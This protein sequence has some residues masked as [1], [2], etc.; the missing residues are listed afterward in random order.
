M[1]NKVLI[2]IPARYDSSRFPGKP[3]AKIN[4]IPMIKRTYNQALKNKYTKDILVATDSKRILNFCNEN[5]MNVIMTS[6]ECQSGTDRVAEVSK[7]MTE[8]DCYFNLQG[9]EPVINPIFINKCIDEYIKQTEY[10]I[11]SGYAKISKE[12]AEIPQKVKVVMNEKNEA[13]YF[14]RSLIPN[15]ANQYHNH[16]GIYCFSKKVLESFSS[17]ERTKNERAEQVE[18]I[19]MIELGIKIK[20]IEVEE[21]FAVDI[22]S[23]IDKV[24][25]FLNE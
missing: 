12:L 15:N 25:K 9:D 22:P 8:F 24:E 20:M 5:D 21:T 19:R 18:L 11:I 3:L 4:G 16:I 14:S 7:K 23:D 10:E 6:K 17:H 2:V 1:K 13:M